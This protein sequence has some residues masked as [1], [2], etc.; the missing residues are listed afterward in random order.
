LAKTKGGGSVAALCAGLVKPI[1][2][3]LG[4][5]VWDVVYEKEGS[6]WYLR[7]YIEHTVDEEGVCED[8]TIDDCVAVTKPLDKALDELDPTD[9]A[10]VLEVSSPGLE[11]RLTRPEH[12]TRY[13]GKPVKTRYVREQNGVR[14]IC[15]VLESFDK[16]TFAI[17]TDDGKTEVKRSLTAFI[18]AD[19]IEFFTE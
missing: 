3:S 17:V 5:S 18:K 7:V 13:I 8:I 12:L 10:Y 1:A 14:E 6:Q 16:E 11:R 19:D 2:E 15:G 9:D 4:L